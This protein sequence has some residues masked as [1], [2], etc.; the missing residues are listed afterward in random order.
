MYCCLAELFH[1]FSCTIRYAYQQVSI[2]MFATDTIRENLLR[3][4][5]LDGASRNLL[6]LIMVTCGY[7]E[8]RTLAM[9]RLEI[10]LQNPKVR[11]LC[12]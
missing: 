2:E 4:Q 9:Q 6:K 8:V 5:T 11:L 1:F 12:D 3:R 7:S 10:W